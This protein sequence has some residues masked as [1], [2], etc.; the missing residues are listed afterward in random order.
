MLENIKHSIGM[1]LSLDL[2]HTK[3]MIPMNV[4]FECKLGTKIHFCQ[5]M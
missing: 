4:N 1:Q 3:D 5:D 2:T